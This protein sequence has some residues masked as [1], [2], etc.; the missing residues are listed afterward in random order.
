MTASATTPTLIILNPHAGSGRAGRVWKDLE[1]LLWQELGELLVAVT[2]RA[3]DV[4]EHLDKAYA[5]GVRRVISIG[6][7][8]TNH[9]LVNALAAQNASAPAAEPMTYGALPVGTGQDWARGNGIPTRDPHDAA[10]WIARATP[11]S[12]DLGMLQM[13]DTSEY[14]L[15]IASA[16]LGGEVS[17][18][19]NR[20][21]RRRPWTFLKSTVEGILS[22]QPQHLT[23]RLDGA[24]WFD[25]RAFIVAVANGT[26]FGHGMR[27]APNARPDDGLFDVLVVRAVPRLEV[28]RTLRRVY[29]GS[30]LSHPAVMHARAATVD[31]ECAASFGLELDGES[32]RGQHARFSVAP[33]ALKALL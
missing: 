13:E 23:V 25:G 7:D 6:G 24:P 20:V 32:A 1:P 8:G 27:I 19:V 31:V 29:D 21:L 15:N 10:R 4:A 2:E 11:Q 18:R 14:F 33:G 17:Q 5:V 26:T 22:Y 3:A 30:H 28:L 9:A 16:G 12:L